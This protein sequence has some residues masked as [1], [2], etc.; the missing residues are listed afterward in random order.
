MAGVPTFGYLGAGADVLGGVVG[1]I[2]A[3]QAGAGTAAADRAAAQ[4]Y[5]DNA[6][7]AGTTAANTRTSLARSQVSADYDLNKTLGRQGALYGA[8]GIG[9]GGSP[10]DVMGDTEAQIQ[11]RGDE[12]LVPGRVCREPGRT[13]GDLRHPGREC[14]IGRRPGRVERRRHRR[15]QRD[16]R[17]GRQ[18]VRHPQ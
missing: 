10:L 17:R 11:V 4:G 5:Q 15:L 13:A 2:G 14:L 6:L 12:P 8:A 3:E 1:A 16:P 7:S 18:R 9:P